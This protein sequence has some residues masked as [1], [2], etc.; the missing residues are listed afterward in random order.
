MET[1]LIIQARLGSSR[2]PNKIMLLLNDMPII[3]WVINRCKTATTVDKVIVATTCNPEDDKLVKYLSENNVCYYRG[4]E[5]DLLDRYYQCA[6]LLKP[7]NVVR[8]T[9][10]CP[11]ID[12]TQIDAV[13][14]TFKYGNYDYLHNVHFADEKVE[15]Y[16]PDGTD[17]AVIKFEALEYLWKNTKGSLREHA[18]SAMLLYRDIFT[19]GTKSVD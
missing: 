9:S 1:L 14:K 15:S 2:L 13:V 6:K 12:P 17:V 19:I 16:M 3:D 7:R 5:Y 8:V 10:D 4:S 11:F 18:T